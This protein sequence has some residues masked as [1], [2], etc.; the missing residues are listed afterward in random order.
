M[1]RVLICM[2]GV[3]FI[4]LGSCIEFNNLIIGFGVM[5]VGWSMVLMG[6]KSA[7]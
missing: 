4:G 6:S 3:I 2:F 5:L 1:H 7:K